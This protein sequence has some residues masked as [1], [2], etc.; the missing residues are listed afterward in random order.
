MSPKGNIGDCITPN[1]EELTNLSKKYNISK[2]DIL[3]ISLNIDGVNSN[4]SSKRLRFRLNSENNEFFIATSNN[5]STPWKIKYDKLYLRGTIIGDVTNLTEDTCDNTYFRR[6]VKKDNNEIATAMTL[7]SNSRS[8]CNGCQFCGTYILTEKDADDNNLTTFDRL[9]KKLSLILPKNENGLASL[10]DIEDVG[11]VT[12]C[13]KDEKE[14]VEHILMVN[15]VL[16]NEFNFNG[17]L[18]YIGSQIKSKDALDQIKQNC[19]NFGYYFTIEC[20]ERRDELLKPSKRMTLEETREILQTAK[21]IGMETGILY[22]LGLDSIESIR[23][24]MPLYASSLTR[25]PIINTMQDY[26]GT[27]FLLRN[28]NAANIEYYLQT[29]SIIEN[30]F[31]KRIQPKL[32]ENYRGIFFNT[33]N[34]E[35]LIEPKI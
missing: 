27:H 34:G 7:N 15:D 5:S 17:L 24:N 12:G 16:K 10:K 9:S 18:K 13:F 8:S 2:E 20:F 22:I 11:I 25:I 1:I 28:K 19:N 29:R 14:T 30:V 26:S 4:Y 33:F 3:L 31:D 35:K 23:E 32:W 6:F 21:D